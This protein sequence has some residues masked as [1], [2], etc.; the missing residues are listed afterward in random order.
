MQGIRIEEIYQEILDGKRK[1]FPPNTW[2]E[3]IKHELSKRV[4][5][6]LIEDVLNWRG[7]DI[8]EQWN[9]KLIKKYKLGGVLG[10]VY[11]ASPYTMLNDLY[12]GRFKE[13]EFQQS[14]VS[15]NFW[16]K[17]QGLEALRWTIEEKEKL[18]TEQLLQVYSK[19]WLIKT[20]L[21]RPFRVYWGSSPYAMLND[22]YPGRFKEWELKE[23][24]VNFWTKEQGLEALRW[25]IE[26]KEKLTTEKLLQ[27]YGK[28]WLNENGLLTPLRKHWNSSPYAMLNGLYPGRFR[29][30]ELKEV[31]LN[32]WTKEQGLEV[33]RW[34]IEE[35]ERL[36]PEKLLQVYSERWLIKNR[37]STPLQKHWRGNRYA[38]LKALY[39]EIYRA[40]QKMKN[41]EHV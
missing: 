12:P 21:E 6:Y 1:I 23:V 41:V 2:N 20:Q 31:P 4:T 17:E 25:T 36:T 33:L 24:P 27:V 28:R 32:F 19:K 9:K 40:M 3:D 8:K 13:W 34:T 38:M 18:T 7:E 5:R 15:S 26:E 35:K 10:I 22:L 30:W 29:E 11:Q 16:T 37:L 39:P 14:S